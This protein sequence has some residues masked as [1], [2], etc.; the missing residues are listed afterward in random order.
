MTGQILTAYRVADGDVVF[1]STDQRW[2]ACLSEGL[3]AEDDAGLA[4]LK[5]Q[6]RLAAAGTE[7][8]DPY[9]FK[10]ERIDAV[11]RP[12]H[13]RERIRSLGPTV[14]ADLGKQSSSPGCALS[15]TP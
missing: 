12:V 2:S 10:A 1:F 11:L 5:E 7:V 4:F 15:A 6:L 8:T 14:R 9:L 3:L 13:I